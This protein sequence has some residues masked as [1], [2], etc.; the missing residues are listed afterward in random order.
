[1]DADQRARHRR[2]N[3]SFGRGYFS[4]GGGIGAARPKRRRERII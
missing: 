1:M 3:V 4:G 2:G